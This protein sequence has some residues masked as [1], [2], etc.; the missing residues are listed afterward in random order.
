MPA[1]APDRKKGSRYQVPRPAGSAPP[2]DALP[3]RGGSQQHRGGVTHPRQTAH[4]NPLSSGTD[5]PSGIAPSQRAARSKMSAIAHPSGVQSVRRAGVNSTKP[6]GQRDS[7]VNGPQLVNPSG[8]GAAPLGRG[9]FSPAHP[10][11]PARRSSFVVVQQE[12]TS[13]REFLPTM[14]E[15]ELHTSRARSPAPSLSTGARRPRPCPVASRSSTMSTLCRLNGVLVDL[16]CRFR[17]RAGILRGPSWPA[18]LRLRTGRTGAQGVGQS[19][20]KIKP[21]PQSPK[22]RPPGTA[23]SASAGRRSPS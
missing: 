12:N 18:V 10:R 11:A 8:A 9:L 13:R 19:R 20:A 1:R 6:V 5:S 15:I 17:I 14:Q 4:G 7:L 16:S 3:A 21:R 22:P 2:A 23:D